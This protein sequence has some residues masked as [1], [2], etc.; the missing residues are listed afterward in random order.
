[1]GIPGNPAPEPRSIAL[2][3]VASF[4]NSLAAKNDSPK[5]RET[6]SSGV[7]TAVRFVLAFHFTSNAKYADTCSICAALR[8]SPARYGASKELILLSSIAVECN[9]FDSQIANRKLQ[10]NSACPQK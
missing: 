1:M 9:C 6:I 8:L 5:C 7:R 4:N 2:W 3:I 10:L